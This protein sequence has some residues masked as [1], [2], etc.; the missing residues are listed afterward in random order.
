MGRTMPNCTMPFVPKFRKWF[1]N[2]FGDLCHQHDVAYE[3]GIDRKQ[4]DYRLAS[5][6]M[7]RE[8]AILSILVLI[9]VRVF[10]RGHKK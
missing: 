7:L 4:A 9:F 6:I 8:Y 3:R 10:G 1:N 2:K 5:Q